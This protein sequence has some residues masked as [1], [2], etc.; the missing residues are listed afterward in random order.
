MNK[1]I[2]IV[3]LT[4]WVILWVNFILRDL[5]KHGKFGE[6]IELMTRR[7]ED[8]RAYVYGE[9]FYTF[10]NFCKENVK[11]GATFSLVGVEKLSLTHRRAAYYL[12]PLL[13]TGRH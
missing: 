8:K 7:T 13:R 12:Y 3:F 11:A 10:L 4:A 1:K 5:V 6:Y 9:K 2:F